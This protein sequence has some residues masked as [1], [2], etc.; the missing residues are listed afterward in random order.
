MV[1]RMLP[2]S[3]SHDLQWRKSSR[4]ASNGACVEVAVASAEAIAMRDSKDPQGPQLRF[5]AASWRG[6]V[7]SVRAGEFARPQS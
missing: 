7:A 1:A 3:H 6:F 2:A 4:S 5:S